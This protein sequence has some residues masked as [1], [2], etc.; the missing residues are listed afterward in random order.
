MPASPARSATPAAAS[1]M[2]NTPTLPKT[3]CRRRNCKT[4]RANG[5]VPSTAAFA[6]AAATAN[7]ANAPNMAASMINTAGATNWPIV[8]ATY[9]LIPKNPTDADRSLNVMQ[10]FDWA[11]NNGQGAADSAALHHAAASCAPTS[12]SALVPGSRQQPSSLDRLPLSA[13]K[14]LQG[15][16]GRD[17]GPARFLFV[18][19]KTWRQE[20]LV[21]SFRTMRSIDPETRGQGRC[22]CPKASGVKCD[23]RAGSIALSHL[24]PKDAL[25]LKVSKATLAF[26]F[27][28]CPPS[29]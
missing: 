25:D 28:L 15:F 4:V 9:I 13:T 10:F 19:A 29:N 11:F 12:A 24:M 16:D 18:G 22:V 20:N 27:A 2:S 26:K 1:A 8:S 17:F 7:W 6:A 21:Q 14:K 5:F 3:T 23:P